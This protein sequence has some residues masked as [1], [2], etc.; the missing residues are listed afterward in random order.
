MS[1]INPQTK[2]I[3]CKIVYFGPPFSGKSTTL[4]Q[5]FSQV[6]KGKK[7]G[8]I[9]LTEGADRTLFF[10]FLPLTLGQVQGFDLRIH[11]YSV[12]GQSQFEAS[13][14]MILTG[15]DGVVFVADSQVE[16]LEEN[17]RSWRELEKI[18]RGNGADFSTIPLVIQL[19]KRDLK[20]AAPARD[21]VGLLERRT[22]PHVE[23]VATKGEGVMDGLITVAKEVLRDLKK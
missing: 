17:L 18:L 23:T 1:F 20:N 4:R 10:D 19:N 21:I 8:M 9:S 22:V 2:E 14:T 11:L 16:R 13:Q 12:P 15:V 6:S 5:V 7:N 3:S